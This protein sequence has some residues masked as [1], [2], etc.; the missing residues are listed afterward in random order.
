MVVLASN[1]FYVANS[2]HKNNNRIIF[3]SALGISVSIF[4]IILLSILTYTAYSATNQMLMTEQRDH[5]SI[6]SVN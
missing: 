1:I 3:S 2:F 5:V 6:P 4:L